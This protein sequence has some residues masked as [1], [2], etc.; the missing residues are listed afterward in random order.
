MYNFDLA[1]DIGWG[2]FVTR[3]LTR[4][5]YKRVLQRDYAMRL[6]TGLEIILP[7]DNS[8]VSEV[9]LTG[10]NVDWGAEAEMARRLDAK[11][12]FI[13]VG[14]HIGYYSL[15]MRPRVREVHAFEPDSRMLR[16]LRKNLDRY[17]GM[18]VHV[19]AVSDRPGKA[20]FTLDKH[21]ELSRMESAGPATEENRTEVT[22]VSLDEFA[23]PSQMAVT[24]IKID[25]EGNDY[26]VLQGASRLVDRCQ[27]LILAEAVADE[28]LFSWAKNHDYG[29]FATVC[30]R[31]TGR[32][33]FRRLTSPQQIWTK[34]LF[35][36]PHRLLPEFC[37]LANSDETLHSRGGVR[38]ST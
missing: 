30:D 10:A 31:A 38:S 34:M 2:P 3:T 35:L 9:I 22:V 29:V 23:E 1:R 37:S 33:K 32:R 27:P 21:A 24:G 16:H 11:G 4:Q 18:H 25:V 13:D 6:P 7:P 14:A 26:L 8:F 5:F 28:K 17:S 15:Y 12:V 20:S 36:V 19:E